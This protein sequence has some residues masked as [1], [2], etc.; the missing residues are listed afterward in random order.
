MPAD[1]LAAHHANDRAVRSAYR[2][3]ST[4]S[5]SDTVAKLLL[6]YQHLTAPT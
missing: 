6:L 2:F 5:E 4:L 3:S 1:L